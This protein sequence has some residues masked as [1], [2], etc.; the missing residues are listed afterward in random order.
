MY[1]KKNNDFRTGESIHHYVEDHS[2]SPRSKL[3][4]K[5]K[6][7]VVAAI[8]HNNLIRNVKKGTLDV[9][10]TIREK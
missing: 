6:N 4:K 7:P 3:F 2:N 1:W 9:R 10:E 8:D 5:Y